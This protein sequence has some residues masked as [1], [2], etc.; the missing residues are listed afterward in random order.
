MLLSIKP[1]KKIPADFVFSLCSCSNCSGKRGT[2]LWCIVQAKEDY[3]LDWM[4]HSSR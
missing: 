2:G 1:M 3:S 4:A